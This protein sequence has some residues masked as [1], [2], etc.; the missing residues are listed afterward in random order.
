MK[1]QTHGVVTFPAQV[2]GPMQPASTLVLYILVRTELDGMWKVL[3]I[4][5]GKFSCFGEKHEWNCLARNE[6]SIHRQQGQLMNIRVWD[7]LQE[8]MK[9]GEDEK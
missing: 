3:K 1:K 4:V 8:S 5:P 2:Q 6:G 9:V 7:H